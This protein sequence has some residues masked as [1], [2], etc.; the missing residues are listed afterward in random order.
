MHAPGRRSSP[1]PRGAR[2]SSPVC[3]TSVLPWPPSRERP[4]PAQE[5]ESEV[6]DAGPLARGRAL[7][8]RAEERRGGGA[9]VLGATGP[10][11]PRWRSWT[12]ARRGPQRNARSRQK[13]SR[14]RNVAKRAGLVRPPRGVSVAPSASE[15]LTATTLKVRG[16]TPSERRE[17]RVAP[18]ATTEAIGRS[19]ARP[20]GETVAPVADQRSPCRSLRPMSIWCNNCYSWSPAHSSRPRRSALASA[21]HFVPRRSNSYTSR[22]PAV[23]PARASATFVGNTC[24]SSKGTHDTDAASRRRSRAPATPS[25][26]MGAHQQRE[27]E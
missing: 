16:R 19:Q 4:A 10:G 24:T 9:A 6:R 14:G 25:V 11:G 2:P 18:D 7:H 22:A 12:R 17:V 13:G 21:D 27:R 8:R 23:T 26:A 3:T 20:F 15:L 5:L 1:S